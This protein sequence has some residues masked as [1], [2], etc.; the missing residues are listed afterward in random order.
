M[1][2]RPLMRKREGERAPNRNGRLRVPSDAACAAARQSGVGAHPSGTTRRS[3]NITLFYL[4]PRA[5]APLNAHAPHNSGEHCAVA[6][7][8]PGSRPGTLTAGLEFTVMGLET[9]RSAERAAGFAMAPAEDLDARGD[10]T[11]ERRVELAWRPAETVAASNVVP[12]A[13]P[14]TSSMADWLKGL[15][16]LSSGRRAAA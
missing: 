13:T 1:N 16:G 3:R 5:A 12:S 6:D 2:P 14:P 8:V 11:L 9:L 4:T 10:E 15:L 7:P